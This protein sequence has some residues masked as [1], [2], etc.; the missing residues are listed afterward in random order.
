MLSKLQ[1]II[2]PDSETHRQESALA[3]FAS[4]LREIYELLSH[5][6]TFH[7]STNVLEQQLGRYLSNWIAGRPEEAMP[8]DAREVTNGPIDGWQERFRISVHGI[9]ED[10][11]VEE[12]RRARGQGS[13]A[14]ERIF[15]GWR[16]LDA[17]DFESV[18]RRELGGFGV[19]TI[20]EHL[21]SVQHQLRI[22]KGDEPFD[23]NAML[24]S[25]STTLLLSVQHR[26]RESGV[27]EDDI[28]IRTA[29]FFVTPTLD[30]VPYLKISCML[31]AAM[32]RK[33]A[34]GGQR[35][36]PNR[37]ALADVRTI[38]TVLP[39]CD[40]IFID[41]EMANYLREEPLRSEIQWGTRVFSTNTR[42][43][44]MAYLVDIR[45]EASEEHV[46]LVRQVYGDGYLRPFTE[47]LAE[48]GH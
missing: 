47:V 44:F 19:S 12:L 28:W 40:A 15:E 30:R 16:A 26:L 21:R 20:Q 42:E 36:P 11:W 7:A 33:A 24:P 39:Y 1:L 4:S 2:C 22:M 38:S 46:G 41:N 13:E 10:D 35:R 14:M 5:G 34:V 37:G 29:E 43:D 8:I 23:L 3:P 48:R 9:G 6:T 17:F 27:P 31:F 32:A 45:N 25:S 18:F